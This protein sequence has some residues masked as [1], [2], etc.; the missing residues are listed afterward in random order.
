MSNA[1]VIETGR[2]TAGIIIA[3]RTGFRFYASAPLFSALEGKSFANAAA[4]ERACRA[5]ESA[6]RG[7]G[8]SPRQDSRGQVFRSWG[9]GL[10]C[11]AA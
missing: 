2:S 5:L 9:A 11:S 1:I 3:E 8:R 10:D 4:A 6:A 7:K